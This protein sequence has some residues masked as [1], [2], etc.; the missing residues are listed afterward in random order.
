MSW[1][2]ALSLT[3]GDSSPATW[4][5]SLFLRLLPA[6]HTASTPFGKEITV[7]PD[8]ACCDEWIGNEQSR[9][10]ASHG[11]SCRP[12]V[13]FRRKGAP[14]LLP[15]RVRDQHA[16]TR[17]RVSRLARRPGDHRPAPVVAGI[18]TRGAAAWAGPQGPPV[19]WQTARSQQQFRV[20]PRSSSRSLSRWR[21][22]TLFDEAPRQPKQLLNLLHWE[23]RQE[24]PARPFSVAIDMLHSCLVPADLR[25][26]R[27]RILGDLSETTVSETIDVDGRDRVSF[28]QDIRGNAESS[29]WIRHPATSAANATHCWRARRVGLPAGTITRTTSVTIAVVDHSGDFPRS[30]ALT[31]RKVGLD[32]SGGPVLTGNPFVRCVHESR[33]AG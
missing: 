2:F 14:T 10:V 21:N 31:T 24:P 20:G 1:L 3:V 6:A 25:A 4:P 7:A 9:L 32:H 13:A 12:L 18:R 16:G 26:A 22:A 19:D 27:Y 5:R 17:R 28:A 15:R 8:I 29:W 11:C 23:C 30:S 33:P